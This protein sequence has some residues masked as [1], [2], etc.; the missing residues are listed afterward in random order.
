M[1]AVAGAKSFPFEPPSLSN[2]PLSMNRL[3][4]TALLLSLA[5]FLPACTSNSSTDK[6]SMGGLP[7]W[8]ADGAKLEDEPA[9]YKPDPAIIS[10]EDESGP[11][12]FEL[13]TDKRTYAA[14]PVKKTSP[15][16]TTDPLERG[17]DSR[18][19]RLFR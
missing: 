19:K 12:V 11:V 4:L 16:R 17:R 7:G 5:A 9:P 3:P 15:V 1:L 18:I 6:F 14:P 2:H 10:H 8:I 13:I